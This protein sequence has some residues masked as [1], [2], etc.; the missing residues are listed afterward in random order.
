M[1][2]LMFLEVRP[3]KRVY[4]DVLFLEVLRDNPSE[5]NVQSVTESRGP[6]LRME[7]PAGG[8]SAESS[9]WKFSG[10]SHFAWIV[11]DWDQSPGDSGI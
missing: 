8:G 11:V 5:K 9:A 3:P 2:Y 1:F 4:R 10:S 6:R 7:F